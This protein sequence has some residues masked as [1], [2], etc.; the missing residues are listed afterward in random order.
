MGRKLSHGRRNFLKMAVVLA[1]AATEKGYSQPAARAS[2][3]QHDPF[4]K[5]KG[6]R[7]LGRT[8]FKVSDLATGSIMDGGVLSAMLDTG[9]NFIDTAESYP[10]HHRL[11]GSAIKDRDRKSLFINTKMQAEGDISREGFIKRAR[12]SLEDL[13]TDYV[14]CMMLHMPETV[15]ELKNEGFHAAMQELRAEGRVRF[16]GLSNHGSFWFRD[17]KETME[18]VLLAAVDDG[19]FDV[20]LMG[21]NFLQMDQ[22][23]RVLEASRPKKIG[24]A[25]MKTTPVTEYEILKLRLEL[26]EKEGKEISPL[27]QEGLKRFREK[28]ERAEG[29]I[30]KY[31]LKNPDEVKAAAIRFV[32]SN[33]DVHTVCCSVGTYEEMERVVRLSGSRLDLE[34]QATLAAYK[35]ACGEFYCRHACGLCELECPRHVPVNTIMRYN[36]YFLAQGREKEAMLKY[37]QIPGARAD[38]CTNCLGHCER[39]CPY[40]VPVQGMLLLAHHQL[41][42]A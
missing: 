42:L 7:L 1:G 19:R 23:E 14:D 29:F 6:Y 36:H 17:P 24:I 22:A 9:V 5:I 28:A 13:G 11:V 27:F 26:L 32:L 33:P 35:A 31:G 8:G 38:A 2:R 25:L 20:F 37:S 41:T 16:V 4:P 12:K 34:G 30:K 18:R 3:E 21:Y 10:G 39:A 15:E 40:G